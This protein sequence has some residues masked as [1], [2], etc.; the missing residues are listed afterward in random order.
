MENLQ[1]VDSIQN[2][3]LT[4]IGLLKNPS[5]EVTRS[6]MNALEL[7]D[8]PPV[9]VETFTKTRR[10]LEESFGKDYSDA[11]MAVLFDM[12]REDG[13]SELRFARTLKWFLK[14]KHFKDWTIADW[15]QYGVKVYPYAW[16][17]EQVSKNGASVNAQIETYKLP[18]GLIVY[19]YRDGEELPFEKV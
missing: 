13:W 18:S 4:V 2:R 10:I 6:G 14:T 9:S 12:M 8:S 17:L 7:I 1:R 16:Y 15:F 3:K 19:R 11:K 5:E